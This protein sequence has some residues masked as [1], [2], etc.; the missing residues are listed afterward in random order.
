M[1]Y[2]TIPPHIAHSSIRPPSLSPPVQDT[3]QPPS[4][5][6]RPSLAFP[7]TFLRLGKQAL[8][9]LGVLHPNPTRVVSPRSG[10]AGIAIVL[11]LLRRLGWSVNGQ[12]GSW[13]AVGD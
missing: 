3:N 7:P 12:L 2:V 11:W 9:A 4:P 10:S 5:T 13:G 8:E 1:V 6:V